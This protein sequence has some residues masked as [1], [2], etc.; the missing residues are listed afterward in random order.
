LDELYPLY[1]DEAEDVEAT[2]EDEALIPSLP[3]D[4]V[5][6]SFDAPTQEEVK[7]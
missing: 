5:I 1:C 4:E 7:W 3:F 2:H 6:Q